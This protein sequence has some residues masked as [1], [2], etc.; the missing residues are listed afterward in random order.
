MVILLLENEENDV[1]FFRRALSSLGFRGA[2]QV[3][4]NTSL[5]RAYLEGRPPYHVRDY[6]PMPD[7]II[8]DMK[9]P[10]GSGL[11]FLNWVRFH[12]EFKS[13]PFAMLS[14]S[15][16]EQE[17]KAAVESGALLYKRK[18]GDFAEMRQRVAELL[19][20]AEGNPPE[21]TGKG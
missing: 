12:P 7:L 1:F 17:L 4:Q 5:A 15:M 16:M 21:E 18:S 14:G 19:E 2:V 13:I 3:V 8:S 9:M 11:E 6:H 20:L 10:G